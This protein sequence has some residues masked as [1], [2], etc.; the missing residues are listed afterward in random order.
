MRIW[1]RLQLAMNVDFVC[2]CRLR[3][4]DYRNQPLSHRMPWSP[5]CAEMLVKGHMTTA[6]MVG[7]G[8]G[9]DVGEHEIALEGFI[10]V[11][12]DKLGS[13]MDELEHL[14]QL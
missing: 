2:P 4:H 5:S 12:K 8:D 1:P 14:D 11:A 10:E 7:D 13:E 9:V 3:C 6:G